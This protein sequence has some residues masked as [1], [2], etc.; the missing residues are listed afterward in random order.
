MMCRRVCGEHFFR[1]LKLTCPKLISFVDLPQTEL[2]CP[3]LT[4]SSCRQTAAVAPLLL[5]GAHESFAS[6]NE[7]ELVLVVGGSGGIGQ[8]AIY[9]LLQRGY[10]V[11]ACIH[12]I[13]A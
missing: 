10:K 1:C 12:A 11:R 2:I 5:V 3:K 7:G 9:D 4:L 13:Q 8:F 6:K